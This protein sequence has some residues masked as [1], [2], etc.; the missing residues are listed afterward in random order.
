MVSDTLSRIFADP[1]QLQAV[2]AIAEKALLARQAREASKKAQQL[3]RDQ[4]KKKKDKYEHLVSGKFAPCTTKDPS[5]REF[6]IVEGE[7]AGGSAKQARDRITQAIQMLKG[8]VLNVENNRIDRVLDNEEIRSI[9][10]NLGCGIGDECDPDKLQ[11]DKVVIM[12][13]ADED[14][15]HIRIL[16]LT[17]FFRYMLQIV[18]AG[19]V[20][21]A[22]PPLYKVYKDKKVQ[23]AW[24]VKERDAGLKKLGKGSLSQRFKGL[25]EMNP[26]QLWDTTMNPD[27]RRLYKVTV[28]DVLELDQMFASL[29][30]EKAETRRDFL[31]ENARHLKDVTV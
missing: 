17:F 8:K 13:D 2:K 27:S 1:K 14:G 31:V 15:S 12:T 7:S 9:I 25:G 4:E 23:Y 5:K 30:G 26:D 3:I 10:I 18:R 16:L 20:Y 22:Q 6:F 24:T 21:I 29:M 11:Y 28:D 19:C